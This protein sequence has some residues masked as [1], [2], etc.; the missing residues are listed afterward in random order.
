MAQDSLLILDAALDIDRQPETLRFLAGGMPL[1]LVSN[2]PRWNTDALWENP[3]L[4]GLSRVFHAVFT[5]YSLGAAMPDP[6]FYRQLESL[7]H[8]SP[9]QM[10]LV[11]PAYIPAIL[12]AWQAGWQTVWVNPQHLPAPGLHPLHDS[13]LTDLAALPGILAQP[14]LPGYNQAIAWLV[15]H[16]TPYNIIAHVQLVA[17][18]T[19]ELAVWL[20]QAGVKVQPLLAH[21]GALLHD[22]C[23]FES[24]L[25][26]QRSGERS[27]HARLAHHFLLAQGQPQLAEI[28]D[29]HMP[30]SSA[31]DER[32]P[33]TW[34]EKLV[35]F[36][37]KMA[38]GTRLVLPT[39]RIQTLAERY[40]E[41]RTEIETS[42]PF[43][44]QLQ[45][46]ICRPLKLT[47]AQL[48]QQLTAN[49]Q[50]PSG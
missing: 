44:L 23:K 45:D 18:V 46:E 16:H 38:E 49:Y 12:G 32:A 22:L 9:D 10:I 4:A 40:P 5:P 21:R 27:D 28:A 35:H 31:S 11:S 33:L 19:Y 17:T 6:A 42:L 24:I 41:F 47:P 34:E 3:H 7:Y 2:D 50:P 37:D 8:R 15:A 14:S 43:L 39:E 36:A 48:F 1:I 20:C 26:H 30:V 29:R 13:E 25:L